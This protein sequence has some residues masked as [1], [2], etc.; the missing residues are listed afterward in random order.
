M[1]E[2]PE[3]RLN[4]KRSNEREMVLREGQV[5]NKLVSF[6]AR[7]EPQGSFPLGAESSNSRLASFSGA[8]FRPTPPKEVT[9]RNGR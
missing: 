5:S 4:S 8:S 3:T 2:M 7:S 1:N 9:L 6:V